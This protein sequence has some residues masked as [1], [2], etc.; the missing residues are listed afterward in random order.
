MNL[1]LKKEE[2]KNI[3]PLSD[4]TDTC[5][6][7][8]KRI[9][10]KMKLKKAAAVLLTASL[11]FSLSV[12]PV[13]ADNV[14]DLKE[15]KQA[16][17]DEVSSLQ[18][19]LNTLMTKITELENDLITTGE[20]ITQTEADLQTAQD[21]EQKQYED[22]KL[23]IKYM[24]EAGSGSAAVE[25]VMTTGS[26]SGMLTQAEYSQQVHTFDR[27]KLKEY[28]ETVQKVKDLQDTL[29]TKMDDLKKT[30]TEFEAQQDELNTTIT[31]KSA[32]VAN[33]DDQLQA[34]IKKAAEEEAAR[35]KAAEEAAAKKAAQQ[36][37]STS[38]KNTSGNTGSTTTKTENSTVNNNTSTPST[39]T[40][41]VSTPPASTPSED[42][43]A[44]DTPVY[45]PD[46]NQSAADIIV[47]AAWSQVGKA[48]YVW[49]TQIPY[50]S[51][52]CSGLVQWCYAQAGISIPRQSTSIKNSGTIVSDPRPG[53]ICWTPGHVAI[54]IGNG[55]MI[56]AQQDGVPI[57]VSKVRATYYIR[58]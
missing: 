47:S 9:G 18:S 35:Q 58:Y 32:E 24:Y 46:Y 23:R 5:S 14:N 2:N 38:N 53:D 56:E 27:Q 16:A 39:S 12:T 19:Q 50:V 25:K 22:M 29:E 17:E 37:S 40:P 52:D 36:S 49:G 43:S 28:A 7:L 4:E 45:T 6:S 55:Q 30:Q 10:E 15:Q 57:C 11:A 31:E 1:F 34:A 48:T 41:S 21:D 44:S 13:L 26:I 3:F 33:L 42:N 20:E 51:F 54:Y 8:E